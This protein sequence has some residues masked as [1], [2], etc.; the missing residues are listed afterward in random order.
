M[1]DLDKW[2]HFGCESVA[3]TTGKQKTKFRSI[4]RYFYG[5]SPK[6]FRKFSINRCDDDEFH[7]HWYFYKKVIFWWLIKIRIS[8]IYVLEILL[9]MFKILRTAD[10]NWYGLPIDCIYNLYVIEKWNKFWNSF[11]IDLNSMQVL[12]EVVRI[13][14]IIVFSIQTFWQWCWVLSA[15]LAEG[16]SSKLNP[17]YSAIKLVL[18]TMIPI[19]CAMSRSGSGKLSI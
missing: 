7:S 6:F 12:S 11:A 10:M 5:T 1:A 14:I 19:W 16:N 2:Y 4:Y 8:K 9:C 15:F 17:Q 13:L 3:P 18:D